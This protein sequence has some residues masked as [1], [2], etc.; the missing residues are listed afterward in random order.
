[1][2]TRREQ[3][4]GIK[5]RSAMLDMI[6]EHI[7]QTGYPP[8]YREIMGVL[9]ISS[10]SVVAYHLRVLESQGVLRK[11]SRLARAITLNKESCGSIPRP[12]A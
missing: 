11:P 1:M 2:T 7:E 3:A 8:T 10:T 5:T 6:R 12:S 9:G 4:R